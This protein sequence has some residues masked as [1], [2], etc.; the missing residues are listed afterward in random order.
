MEVEGYE[1]KGFGTENKIV[2]TLGSLAKREADDCKEHPGKDTEQIS[3]IRRRSGKSGCTS[4]HR[5]SGGSY[6]SA[7]GT[8]GQHGRRNPAVCGAQYRGGDYRIRSGDSLNNE[9]YEI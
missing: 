6:C 8:G 2:C 7:S 4:D 1:Y 3:G 9:V 5:D